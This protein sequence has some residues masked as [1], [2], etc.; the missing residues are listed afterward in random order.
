MAT[1][2]TRPHDIA[3]CVL[4]VSHC[5]L[6]E[7]DLEGGTD[8]TL[9]RDE[10][11]ELFS[12]IILSHQTRARTHTHTPETSARGSGP[13]PLWTQQH[14]QTRRN[15]ITW[16]AFKYFQFIWKHISA[17]LFSPFLLRVSPDD[18]IY[19]LLVQF[20]VV[21]VVAAV[22]CAACDNNTRGG[23]EKDA[24]KCSLNEQTDGQADNRTD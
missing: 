22:W 24:A 23:I 6:S 21:V 12:V 7:S 11:L 9:R 4:A 8:E 3:C 1:T 16:N 10:L 20:E 15:V 18:N 2:P 5:D 17:I 13:D 14:Q 19:N